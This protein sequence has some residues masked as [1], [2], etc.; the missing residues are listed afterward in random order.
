MATTET[1]FVAGIC[2]MLGIILGLIWYLR[3]H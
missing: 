3:K 1:L 2:A